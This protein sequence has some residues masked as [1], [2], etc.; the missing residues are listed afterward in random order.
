MLLVWWSLSGFEFRNSFPL[1][2]TLQPAFLIV[3]LIISPEYSEKT[4]PRRR[5]KSFSSVAFSPRLRYFVTEHV[6]ADIF[7]QISLGGVGSKTQLRIAQL[8]ALWTCRRCKL[9]LY[10]YGCAL[11]VCVRKHSWT[12]M[13]KLNAFCFGAQDVCKIN[14][15]SVGFPGLVSCRDSFWRGE[16]VGFVWNLNKAF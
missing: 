9:R 8:C 13:H 1:T 4:A 7:S 14:I 11:C 15:C 3:F 12:Q 5:L 6:S 10:M 2:K 16:L